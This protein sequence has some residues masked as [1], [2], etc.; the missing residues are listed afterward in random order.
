MVHV[1]HFET[2]TTC[3]VGEMHLAGRGAIKLVPLAAHAPSERE[4]ERE[5]GRE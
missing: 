5:G 2:P 3:G 4:K 1:P